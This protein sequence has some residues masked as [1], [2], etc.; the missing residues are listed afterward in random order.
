MHGKCWFF[1]RNLGQE[2]YS[3]RKKTLQTELSLFEFKHP[4][5]TAL[6]QS[7]RWVRLASLVP[8]DELEGDYSRHF[9]VSGND[10]FPVRVALGALIIKERLKL[11]DEETVAQIRENPYLQYFIGFPQYSTKQP[12]D[13]SLMVHFRSRIS[14]DMLVRVNESVCAPKKTPTKK[15]NDGNKPPANSGKLI[16]DATCAPEDMR[17]PTDLGLLN[18][19]REHSERVIDFL[20]KAA[21]DTRSRKPRTYRKK[22]RRQFLLAIRCR[23]PSRHHLRKGIRQQ[24]G[25]LK[26]NLRTIRGMSATLPLSAL[27]NQDYRKLLVTSEVYRQ[28]KELH[29]M[30]GE[31]HR[32]IDDRIVS[33]S[34]PH[35]RPIV[36]GKASADVEFGAKLSVSVIDGKTYLDRLSWDAYNEGGDLKAQ[37]EAFKKKT[38]AYPE[39]IHADK[40]YR[41][42]ENLRWCRENSIRLSGP[43]LGR[44]LVEEG[45][46]AARRKQQRLDER[47]R[48]EIEGRFGTA[49]RRY[50]LDKIMTKLRATSETTIALIFFVMNLDKI[51]RDLLSS[52][53]EWLVATYLWRN[54]QPHRPV[55]C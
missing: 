44:P 17:H 46:Q 4:F 34:K 31:K 43:V 8:W 37:A 28:Q 16:I 53:L 10:A 48:I 50:C 11:T 19:A 25:F 27:S 45:D 18:D 54:Y 21:G 32:R 47:I 1:T 49:K 20:W 55:S 35:V 41:N 38:G 13:P 39:S 51:L 26:R 5:G 15:S 7:N 36:R 24:L 9:G 52:L 2:M 29:R 22:A 6:D 40:A 33:L 12:F 30:I 14:A 3:H 42:R 23:K